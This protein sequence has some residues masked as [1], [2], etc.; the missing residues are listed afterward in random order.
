[1][2]IVERHEKTEGK[3]SK[4]Q[5]NSEKER[6]TSKTSQAKVIMPQA[7]TLRSPRQQHD[8]LGVLGIPSL[9]GQN[10][11][12]IIYYSATFAGQSVTQ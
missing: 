6:V 10:Q 3:Q 2:N 12:D 8:R 1:L 9:L 5:T 7:C 4:S 11:Q